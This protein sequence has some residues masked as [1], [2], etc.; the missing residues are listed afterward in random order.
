[1]GVVVRVGQARP[2]EGGEVR[3]GELIACW[4]LY[5]HGITHTHTH[6]SPPISSCLCLS[7]LSRPGW[8]G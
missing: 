7:R 3:K 6:T 5:D 1:M 4:L 2:G 8:D